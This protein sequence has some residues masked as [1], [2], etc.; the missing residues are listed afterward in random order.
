VNLLVDIAFVGHLSN[1]DL[2]AAALA[3]VWFNLW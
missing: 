2:A 1:N 3:S